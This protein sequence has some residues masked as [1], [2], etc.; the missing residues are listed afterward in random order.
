MVVM[1][2]ATVVFIDQLL[3][4]FFGSVLRKTV[5]PFHARHLLR[6]ILQ[7]LELQCRN[8]LPR[9]CFGP[10]S[11]KSHGLSPEAVRAVAS[12]WRENIH[13]ALVSEHSRY[14]GLALASN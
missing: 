5:H 13:P 9:S 11:L 14:I 12:Q 7:H 10:G 8:L 2:A 4:S 3:P 6:K 1:A